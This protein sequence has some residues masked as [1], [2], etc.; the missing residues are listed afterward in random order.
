M[1]KEELFQFIQSHLTFEII[2][3]EKKVFWYVSEEAYL[4]GIDS[5]PF[6][7]AIEDMDHWQLVLELM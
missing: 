2:P 1:S 5:E 7:K 3:Q 4:E 6:F